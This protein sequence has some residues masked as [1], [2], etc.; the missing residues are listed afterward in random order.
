MAP[1]GKPVCL[2]GRARAHPPLDWEVRRHAAVGIWDVVDVTALASS[3]R[4]VAPVMVFG[5]HAS[6]RS[7][8]YHRRCHS[9]PNS[10]R[11]ATLAAWATTS[12]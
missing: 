10:E 5:R 1:S 12:P 11:P 9:T 6:C 4:G 8:R 3:P 2:T 7:L